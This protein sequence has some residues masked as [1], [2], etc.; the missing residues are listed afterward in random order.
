MYF[1]STGQDCLNIA[2]AFADIRVIDLVN[3]K[4]E[5]LPK[6]KDGE[7]PKGKSGK[8]Q[9]SNVAKAKVNKEK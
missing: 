6:P 8:P 4:I 1:P 5:S 2:K 3:A 9:K 7:K